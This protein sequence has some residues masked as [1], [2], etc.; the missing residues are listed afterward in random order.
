MVRLTRNVLSLV[1]N[2]GLLLAGT[3]MAWSG[4]LLQAVYHVGRGRLDRHAR[5]W[6]LDYSAWS[7]VH[8]TAALCVSLLMIGHVSLHWKWYTTVIRRKLFAKN[9]LVVTLTLI[10]LAVTITGYTPW[11]IRLTGG[12]ELAR[13][14]VIEVHD[15]IAILLCVYLGIHT[16]RNLP[17]FFR[18]LRRLGAS[19]TSEGQ[20]S[21]ARLARFGSTR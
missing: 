3:A 2:V 19:S 13:R 9:R 16:F 18:A 15:K 12:S 8:V 6:E 10:F 21:S 1:T 17:W 7:N 14:A 11:A 20:A 4:L 5:A